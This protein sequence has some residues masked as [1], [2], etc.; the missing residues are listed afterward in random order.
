[1]VARNLLSTCRIVPYSAVTACWQW[2][3]GL[4]I[5]FI[6]EQAKVGGSSPRRHL[7]DTGDEPLP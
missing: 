5:Y 7:A 3:Q 4:V 6:F 2:T 1:M